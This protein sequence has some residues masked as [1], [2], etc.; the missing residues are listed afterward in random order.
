M[1]GLIETPTNLC[2]CRKKQKCQTMV[3]VSELLYK[4]INSTETTE[5]DDTLVETS[6]FSNKI[7]VGKNK[8][9]FRVL[10]S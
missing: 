4:I 10:A 5:D 8:E 1:N 2:Q 6:S 9:F 7:S 3:I